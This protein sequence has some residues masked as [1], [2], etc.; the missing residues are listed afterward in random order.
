VAIRRHDEVGGRA[1]QGAPVFDQP[2]TTI[3]EHDEAVAILTALYLAVHGNV[4]RGHPRDHGS[5]NHLAAAN[6]AAIHEHH[7]EA[8]E[9]GRGRE[10][11]ADRPGRLDAHRS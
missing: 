1:G 2:H 4:G 7:G 11:A 8:S 10:H 9:V 3:R 6:P 5:G